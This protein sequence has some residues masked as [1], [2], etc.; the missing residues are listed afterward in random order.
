MR[1]ENALA[2]LRK[3]AGSSEPWLPFANVINSSLTYKLLINENIQTPN[4]LKRTMFINY[5]VCVD[6]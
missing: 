1:A 6:N 3:C 5:Y 4:Q 2:R